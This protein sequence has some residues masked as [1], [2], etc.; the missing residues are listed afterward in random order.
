MKFL[1]NK[2][3]GW[4]LVGYSLYLKNAQHLLSKII[5]KKIT[6]RECNKNYFHSILKY[7][8]QDI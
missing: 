6:E 2:L 1:N 8:T 5:G 3:E 4:F 7:N